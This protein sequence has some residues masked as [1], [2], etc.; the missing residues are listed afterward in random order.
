APLSPLGGEGEA[1]EEFPDEQIR[2]FL[3]DRG[4]VHRWL[5]HLLD[6]RRLGIFPVREGEDN[7]GGQTRRLPRRA[8]HHDPRRTARRQM[9]RSFFLFLNVLIIATCGLV[10]ELLAGTAASYLLGD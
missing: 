6:G 5:L 2:D 1:L 8:F 10:Y 9:N 7:P 3:F 4:G